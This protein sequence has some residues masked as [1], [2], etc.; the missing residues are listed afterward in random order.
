M[1]SLTAAAK[2]LAEVRGALLWAR[3]GHLAATAAF[4]LCL[5]VAGAPVDLVLWAVAVLGV[6]G[7]LAPD[8][9]VPMVSVVVGGWAWWGTADPGTWWTLPAALALL[10]V[11]VTAA[12]AG[13]Y[14]STSRLPRPVVARWGRR[15]TAVAA[16]TV[17][18]ALVA[19]GLLRAGAPGDAW[20]TAAVLVLLAV[21]ILLARHRTLHTGSSGRPDRPGSAE[22]SPAA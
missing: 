21:G 2:E 19:Q 6:L 4:L 5:D 9:G 10:L 15:T 20:L 11:H 7:A 22:R 14:P 17:V 13:S 16:V 1:S 3:L 18:A 8:S 12:L